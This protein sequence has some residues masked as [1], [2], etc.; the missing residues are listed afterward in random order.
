NQQAALNASIASNGAPI[1]AS[2]SFN[3]LLPGNSSP[4]QAGI[5]T[6]QVGV[7]A[8]APAGHVAGTAT[9]SRVSDASNSGSCPP[10]CAFNLPSPTVSVAA[11]VYRLA[12]PVVNTASPINLAGRVGGVGDTTHLTSAISISNAS[13]DAFTEGLNVT[14]GATPSGFT[15]SG[16]IT[17]L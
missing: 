4:G 5:G 12:T 10:T 14:R 11:D 16:S 13:P 7:S 2:G 8:A 17:N 6:L 3:Q 15:S 1:T 9:V